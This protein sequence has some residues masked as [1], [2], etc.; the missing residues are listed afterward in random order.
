MSVVTVTKALYQQIFAFAHHLQP[1][2]EESIKQEMAMFFELKQRKTK[3]P[4]KTK[5]QTEEEPKPILVDSALTFGEI[6]EDNR[7]KTKLQ[8][9]WLNYYASVLPDGQTVY[10]LTEAELKQDI[11]EAK[12]RNS[13]SEES[14]DAD[15]SEPLK[16]YVKRK[17]DAKEDEV[18]PKGNKMTVKFKG[19]KHSHSWIFK[20]ISEGVY[21]YIKQ[22]TTCKRLQEKTKRF[23]THWTTRTMRDENGEDIAILKY[24]ETYT[25]SLKWSMKSNTKKKNGEY[26]RPE[27]LRNSFVLK[28][29]RKGGHPWQG[30]MKGNCWIEQS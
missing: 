29:N 24:D 20:K 12:G 23:G 1:A 26:Y 15:S 16:V 30:T 27:N 6:E 10:D 3:K 7:K 5:T 8:N 22:E 19:N 25:P 9:E 11:E 17:D 4:K 28:D 2:S 13:S 18:I 21:E 14:S